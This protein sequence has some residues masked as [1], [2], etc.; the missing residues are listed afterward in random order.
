MIGR[1]RLLL[2][3]TASMA[4]VAFA[5]AVVE[6]GLRVIGYSFPPLFM[7]DRDAGA[8]HRPNA[9]GWFVKEARQ[10]ITINAQGLRVPSD[11]PGLTFS[12]AKPPDTLRIAV[13]GDSFTEAL[14]VTYRERFTHVMEQ[15][16]NRCPAR[17][18]ARVEVINFGVSGTGQARQMALYRSMGRRFDPD[19]VLDMVY[20]GNDFRNNIRA[21][22][23]NPFLPY[24]D[25]DSRGRLLL[26]NRF[27]DD[28]AFRSKLFW[29]N[30]RQEA[31][32]HSRI[33]QLLTEVYVKQV[34]E[35]GRRQV[36]EGETVPDWL[37][38]EP[39]LAF[40]EPRDPMRAHAWRVFLTGVEAWARQVA[41]E[42]RQFMMS[43]FP[44]P[45]AVLPQAWK[46]LKER[47]GEKVSRDRFDRVMVPFAARVGFVFFPV[48]M[49]LAE[50]ARETGVNYWYHAYTAR[51]GGH[52]NAQGHRAMGE[53][54]ASRL[55]AYWR[56]IGAARGRDVPAAAS[57]R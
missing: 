8:R 7:Y 46:R 31:V 40:A 41:A 20:P 32:K 1:R 42:G 36:L 16:L 50:R 3:A 47:Y 13:F 39:S 49:A 2:A 11:S 52:F 19:I 9:A 24:W 28:P 38:G 51:V 14:Q 44:L 34:L 15:R 45:A 6:A 4:A 35:P 12:L 55:C 18:R 53:V 57:S 27:R 21:W 56:R 48:T 17:P 43:A 22:E 5:L 23:K 33:L 54:L 30:M 10:F 26:D 37:P 25:V 29:S